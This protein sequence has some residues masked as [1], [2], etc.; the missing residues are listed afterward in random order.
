MFSGDMEVEHWLAIHKIYDNTSFHNLHYFI[1]FYKLEVYLFLKNLLA[2]FEYN[3][4]NAENVA[5]IAQK[6]AQ[7]LSVKVTHIK[8]NPRFNK[9]KDALI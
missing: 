6:I 1:S 7:Y 5:Q 2:A 3:T 4:L 8:C 9:L